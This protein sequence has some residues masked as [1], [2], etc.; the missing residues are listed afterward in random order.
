MGSGGYIPGILR[1]RER[2]WETSRGYRSVLLLFSFLPPELCILLA[3]EVCVHCCAKRTW[4]TVRSSSAQSLGNIRG[5]GSSFFPSLLVVQPE[6]PPDSDL[7]GSASI[8]DKRNRG[9]RD[10][11]KLV[12][13]ASAVRDPPLWL[14]DRPNQRRRLR[15]TQGTHIIPPVALFAGPNSFEPLT[16]AG[17]DALPSREVEHI[18]ELCP[19]RLVIRKL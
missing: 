17:G 9:I 3:S 19:E 13:F 8:C 14:D 12:G 18:V 10:R 16:V 15:A 7:S 11:H 5:P 2:P 4:Y 1:L 6:A